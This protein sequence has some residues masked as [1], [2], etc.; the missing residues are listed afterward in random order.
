MW[1]LRHILKNRSFDHT[2]K[3]GSQLEKMGHTSRNEVHLE[4]CFAL[5]KI[6]PHLEIWLTLWQMAHVVINGFL[7][8]RRLVKSKLNQCV[9][10]GNMDHN[11][12]NWSLCWKTRKQ[13]KADTTSKAYRGNDT[14]ES[15]FKAKSCNRGQWSTVSILLFQLG[16]CDVVSPLSFLRSISLALS[17]LSIF[18]WSDLLQIL[19]KPVAFSFAFLCKKMVI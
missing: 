3:N 15:N 17:S 18:G 9:T 10:L 7:K 8:M 11:S 1:K 14:R 6:L 19:R 16:L 4:K 12:K 5:W 13:C 2:V